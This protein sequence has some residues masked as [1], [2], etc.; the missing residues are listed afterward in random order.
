MARPVAVLHKPIVMSALADA[1]V[2]PSGLMAT[3]WTAS[4]CP[5]IEYRRRGSVRMRRR[6]L[7]RASV[8]G[9]WW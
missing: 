5:M 6:R 8:V 1:T 2:L 9:E 3:P 4:V 7:L